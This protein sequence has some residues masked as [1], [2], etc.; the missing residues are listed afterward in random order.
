MTESSRDDE[1]FCKNSGYLSRYS[2]KQVKFRISRYA[3]ASKKKLD[4][5]FEKEIT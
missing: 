3:N 2:S 4:L 1:L 5:L